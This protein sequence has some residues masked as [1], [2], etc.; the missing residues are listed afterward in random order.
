MIVTAP[1]G[2]ELLFGEFPAKLYIESF[3]TYTLR[4]QLISGEI[5]EEKFYAKVAASQSDIT[6]EDV[7]S[8]PFAANGAQEIIEDLLVWFA[9]GQSSRLCFWSG[10]CTRLKGCDRGG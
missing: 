10:R 5:V 8:V 1:D 9:R 3:G 2:T 7:L 4:Q 6:R